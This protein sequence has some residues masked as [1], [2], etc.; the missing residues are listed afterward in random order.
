MMFADD[1]IAPEFSSVILPAVAARAQ[2]I[3]GMAAACWTEDPRALDQMGRG[4]PVRPNAEK[5]SD[6]L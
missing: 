3:C 6:D 1:G 4:S 5:A 2:K